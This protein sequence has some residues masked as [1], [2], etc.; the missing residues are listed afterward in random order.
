MAGASPTDPGFG[1]AAEENW[2]MLGITGSLLPEPTERGRYA[3]FYGAVA[4]ALLDGGALP[5]QPRDA[6]ETVR[7]IERAHE[8]AGF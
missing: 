8:I 4:S 1:V 6:L 5:V 2:G 7:I 3:D